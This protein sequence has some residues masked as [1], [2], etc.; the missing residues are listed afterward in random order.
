MKSRKVILISLFGVYLNTIAFGF[1]YGG[2]NQDFGLALVNW[3][4]NPSLYPGDPIIEGFSRFPTLFWPVVA[5]ASRWVDTRLVLFIAFILT[6]VLFFWALTRLLAGSLHDHRLIACIVCAFALSPALNHGTPLS[7]SDVLNSV[8]THTSLSIALLLWVGCFWLE[9]RWVS[10]A[11]LLGFAVYI[12]G[13]FVIFVSFA[14]AGFVLVDW[15]QRKREILLASTLLGAIGLPSL[16]L[17]RG[18]FPSSFPKDY[19]A[20]LLTRYPFHF[21]LRSHPLVDLLHGLAMML[22]PACVIL[23]AARL[24]I[25]RTRRL[26]LLVGFF[27]LPFILGGLA[28]EFLPTPSLI[29]LH[30]LRSESFLLLYSTILVQIYGGRILLSAEKRSPAAIWLVGVPAVLWAFDG[31]VLSGV[32]LTGMLLALDPRARFERLCRHMAQSWIAGAA[33]L[34]V[35][36]AGVIVAARLLGGLSSPGAIAALAAVVGICYA[37]GADLATL[38]VRQRKFALVVC[39]LV[40]L[41]VTTGSIHSSARLW[42]PV[43]PPGPAEVAWREVQQWAKACTSQDTKFLTPPVPG[44]FRVFSERVSWV[45]WK[46][47]NTAF[48]FPPYADEWL[49][50]MRAIG[51]RLQ[52]ARATAQSIQN[53]YKDQ[54]RDYLWRVAREERI[55]YIVQF[56]QVPY[57]IPPVFENERFAVYKVMN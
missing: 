4:K 10:A 38:G 49:R 50:R 16:A 37:Y 23:L 7:D 54:P 11:V 47:G 57:D 51:I 6:K 24:G 40:P 45:E 56:K 31:F 8:Q 28:G 35:M 25:T 46:D 30:L 33:A 39:G 22:V 34:V 21:T 42:N 53:D 26:E 9:G 19:V 18:T 48:N 29:R 1:V 12:N 44:G 5:Y 3:L 36:L 13:L 17:L 43:I 27:L 15:Q 32:L 52:P 55:D 2:G 20:M 41:I 14:F